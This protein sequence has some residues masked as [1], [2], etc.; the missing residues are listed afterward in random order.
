MPLAATQLKKGVLEYCVLALIG[1]KWRYG[2][3]LVQLLG[4]VDGLLSTDGTIYPLLSR[5]RADGLVETQW[6]ESEEGRPRRYYRVTPA[7]RAALNGFKVEWERFRNAVDTVL[8][9]SGGGTK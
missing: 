3:E 1:S 6:R 8:G 9:A 2:F 7:G 5:M 4:S